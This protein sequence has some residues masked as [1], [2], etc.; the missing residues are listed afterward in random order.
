MLNKIYCPFCGFKMQSDIHD[1]SRG[2][3]IGIDNWICIECL[4][5]RDELILFD[6]YDLINIL[7]EDSK[8]CIK[9][10]EYYEVKNESS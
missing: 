10:K 2:N 4:N 5:E 7:N 1:K 6:P 9:L 3:T 8:I